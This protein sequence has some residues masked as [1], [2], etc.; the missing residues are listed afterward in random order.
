MANQPTGQELY[1]AVII[2][3]ASRRAK[4]PNE[5]AYSGVSILRILCASGRIT[6]TL[7]AAKISQPLTGITMQHLQYIGQGRSK[8]ALLRLIRT[9]EM[10]L[11][12][13]VCPELFVD[14]RLYAVAGGYE[15]TITDKGIAYAQS[16][17][18]A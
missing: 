10:H 7:F 4:Y 12:V 14:K 6:T 13:H 8:N 17:L 9:S 15:L 2:G 11:L 3:L 16:I 18:S 1:D 5:L